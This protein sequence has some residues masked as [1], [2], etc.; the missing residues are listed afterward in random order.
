MPDVRPNV[1]NAPTRCY[2]RGACLPSAKEVTR[3]LGQSYRQQPVNEN[4]F[5]ESACQPDAAAAAGCFITRSENAFPSCLGRETA[6]KSAFPSDS[7]AFLRPRDND[8]RVYARSQLLCAPRCTGSREIAHFSSPGFRF[9]TSETEREMT[10]AR[11]ERPFSPSPSPFSIVGSSW[12]IFRGCA[13]ISIQFSSDDAAGGS[14]RRGFM[15][16]TLRYYR[17]LNCFSQR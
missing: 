5:P 7:S 6:P 13:M 12:L 4:G 2:F 10:G 9:R 16:A 17:G 8:F 14:R 1:G 15:D 11:R 3:L